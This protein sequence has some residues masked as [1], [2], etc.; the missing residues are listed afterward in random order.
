MSG[1]TKRIKRVYNFICFRERE[2]NQA[3]KSN[4]KESKKKITRNPEVRGSNL[5]L[6]NN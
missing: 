5:Q 3:G 1:I 6:K 2:K 4:P